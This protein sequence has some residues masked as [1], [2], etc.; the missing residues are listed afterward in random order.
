MGRKKLE[1]GEKGK[2]MFVPN[3]LVPVVEALKSLEKATRKVSVAEQLINIGN[4]L[5]GVI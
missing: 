2:I 1:T 5:K 3:S 4:S